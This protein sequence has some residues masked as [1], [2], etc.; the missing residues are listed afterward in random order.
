MGIETL[1]IA[2]LGASVLGGGVSAVG[3]IMGGQAAQ[4][5]ANYRAQ[6]ARNMADHALAVGRV[7]AQRQ[8]F[9]TASIL[10]QQRAQQSASGI[11]VDVGSP[12]D[13]RAT[14][15]QLGELDTQTILNNATQKAW[16]LRTQATLDE[17][18]GE[19]SAT[20]GW[21]K[22]FSSA[23][24]TASGVGDKWLKYKTTGVPGVWS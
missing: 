2:S 1:A 11:D 17:F 22:G 10:G 16:G 5:A 7:E 24:S 8:G 15:A 21:L 9:K 20:E 3:S 14:A 23:L 4:A 18:S 6:V 19:A 13:V 12:V